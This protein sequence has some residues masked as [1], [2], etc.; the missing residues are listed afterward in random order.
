[1]QETRR[2]ILEILREHSPST[3][4]DIVHALRQK[5]G[6]ITAVTVRHHL[7][8]LQKAGFITEPELRHRNAPGRPQHVYSLTDQAEEIFPNNYKNLASALLQQIEANLPENTV[9]VIIQGMALDMA[10]KAG[11]HDAPLPERVQATVDYLNENGYNAAWEPCNEGFILK[12]E[13]CPYH[14]LA[15]Q[16]DSLCTMDMRL[17][18]ALLGV[19]PRMLH[20]IAEGESS[21]AY[22]IPS[23]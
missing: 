9:N 21:C 10:E 14:Q 11:I 15:K 7:N 23:E 8:H 19:V 12:T 3:V 5:R 13:N 16:T 1:M 6:T 22:L 17:I 20:R 4:D 18:S 2:Q